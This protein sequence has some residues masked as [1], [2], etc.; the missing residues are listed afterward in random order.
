MLGTQDNSPLPLLKFTTNL[1]LINKR[2]KKQKRKINNNNKTELIVCKSKGTQVRK[3]FQV[4][5][6]TYKVLPF[7]HPTKLCKSN[8]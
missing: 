8:G 2:K 7:T 6:E 4:P 5:D 3:F 1:N